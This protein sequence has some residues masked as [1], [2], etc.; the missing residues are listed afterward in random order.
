MTTNQQKLQ[1]IID[2][3]LEIARIQDV[4]IL[5]EKILST[6]RK[7]LNTDAG[8]IYIKVGEELQCRH[9]QN[10]T[11]QKQ[12]ASEE[13]LTRPTSSISV[14]SKSISGYVASTGKTVNISD[15]SQLSDDVP[16]SFDSCY[17]ES[18]H[19]RTQSLLVVPLKYY[20]NETV[21]VMHLIN[22]H[23]ETGEVTPFSEDDIPL[24]KLFANHVAIPI[25]RAQ[26]AR[27]RIQG[28]IRLVTELHD[29][30]ETEAHVNRVG[31]YSVEI[32]KVWAC[33][34]GIPQAKIV[35]NTDIL[36]TAAML[37]DLGKIAIPQ[38]IRQ[39]PDKLTTEEYEIMKQH[40]VKGAQMLLKSSQTVYEDTA[41]QIALNH[42]ERWDGNGYP[43][44]I[45]PLNGQIIPGHED[46]QGRLRGKRGEEIPIFGRVVAIADVY[47]ALSSRRAYRR[48][49]DE[50]TVLTILKR[51]AGKYFDPEMIEA[52][53]SSLD[54]IRAIG[55]K[56]PEEE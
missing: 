45:S 36:R 3:N 18:S 38:K 35:M 8:C 15:I 31:V 26:M 1:Q 2:L 9:I 23:T 42:H 49:L 48:A 55:Q 51:E 20:Q 52:F 19:Y 34:R 43:G 47:D 21:G 17:D 12:L 27:V 44:H 32:Y 54:T 50:T 53:F 37:H 30:E 5:L 39:K 11:L 25:E 28:M 13:K 46:E 4:D 40:T 22:A 16:Y 6:A 41:I 56:F 33:K 24:I 29:P 10:D 14:N 7:L